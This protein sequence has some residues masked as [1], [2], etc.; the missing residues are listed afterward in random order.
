MN[1]IHRP[2]LPHPDDARKHYLSN[3]FIRSPSPEQ[4][5]FTPS[6]VTVLPNQPTLPPFYPATLDGHTG[7]GYG[8]HN[9][10]YDSYMRTAAGPMH[11][12]SPPLSCPNSHSS[13]ESSTLARLLTNLHSRS[14][15]SVSKSASTSHIIR[16][17]STLHVPDETLAVELDQLRHITRIQQQRQSD[18]AKSTFA[19]YNTPEPLSVSPSNAVQD[20][21]RFPSQEDCFNHDGTHANATSLAP[22]SMGSRTCVK[23][24]GWRM[25]TRKK[26]DL[27]KTTS[28]TYPMTTR[29]LQKMISRRRRT[30]KT[31]RSKPGRLHVRPSSVAGSLCEQRRRIFPNSY[32]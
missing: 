29:I 28:L 9:A 16:P 6:V 10:L 25:I 13:A 23:G 15:K 2:T 20:R 24:S 21:A 8:T 11:V 26:P 7:Y 18:K 1:Q 4:I 3:P 19:H 17:W 27:M 14:K 30:L 12:P 5:L 31:I 22:L 32:N